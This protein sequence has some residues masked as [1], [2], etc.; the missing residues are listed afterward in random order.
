MFFLLVVFSTTQIRLFET[1]T[2][3]KL[4]PAGAAFPT[5]LVISFLARLSFEI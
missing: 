1:D 3:N 4:H 5:F 2:L